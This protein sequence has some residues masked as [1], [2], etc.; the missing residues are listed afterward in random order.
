M[1]AFC[2]KTTPK[3]RLLTGQ[4]KKDQDFLDT[5]VKLKEKKLIYLELKVSPLVLIGEIK[6][7]SLQLRTKDNVG[8]AG[9][10]LQLVPWKVLIRLLVVNS[11]HFQNNNS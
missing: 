3:L 11:F 1:N 5:R 2:S 7:L 4:K 10:S 6:E 8:H 9:L